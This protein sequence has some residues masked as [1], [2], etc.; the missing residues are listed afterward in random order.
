[1]QLIIFKVMAFLICRLVS[2]Y[3]LPMGIRFFSSHERHSST[4]N[5][6]PTKLARLLK[7][8]NIS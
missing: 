4:K 6:T 1:M 5:Y 2:F 3:N 8:K 7:V